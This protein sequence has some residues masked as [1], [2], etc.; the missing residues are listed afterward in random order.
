M[1]YDDD[2]VCTL[3]G[4]TPLEHE[5]IEDDEDDLPLGWFK[6]TIVKRELNPEWIYHQEF[7]SAKI[8]GLLQQIEEQHRKEARP[9]IAHDISA[10]YAGYEQGLDQYIDLEDTVFMAP[11]TRSGAINDEIVKVLTNLDMD[12]EYF[13][14][15]SDNITSEVKEQPEKV[16]KE[17]ESD[18]VS[19]E[20]DK[21]E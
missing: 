3:S 21:S 6:V 12:S 11:S 2:Y 8:D 5:E 1:K 19:T 20:E 13:N 17:E 9:M 7:K 16:D 18:K 14:V 10:Q 4:V 15:K